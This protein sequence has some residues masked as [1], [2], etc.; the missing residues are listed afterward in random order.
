MLMAVK[1]LKD[2]QRRWGNIPKTVRK[3]LRFEMEEIADRVVSEMYSMAPQLTGDLAGSI[4]WTWGDAPE[5]SMVIG[6]VGKRS[7]AGMRITIYAADK[8]T[9]YGA[10]QEFGTINMPANP[11]FFPV[12][13]ARKRWAKGRMTRSIK[14]AIREA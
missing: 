11:F 1:G 5:G 14:K 12:W 7:H 9:F 4:A 3:N 2:F 6:S 10:F 13:R 8:D